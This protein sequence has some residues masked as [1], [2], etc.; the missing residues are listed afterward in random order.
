MRRYKITYFRDTE[1]EDFLEVEAIDLVEA[2]GIALV[3]LTY[4]FKNK[5]KEIPTVD[6]IESIEQNVVDF[7]VKKKVDEFIDTVVKGVNVGGKKKIL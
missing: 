3:E 6:K 5:Y 2:V 1:K 4:R 7:D